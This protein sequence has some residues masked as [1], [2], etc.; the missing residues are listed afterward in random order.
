MKTVLET[1]QGGTSYLEKHGVDSARLN[2]EH[3]LSHVLDCKRM[4]LYLDFDRPLTEESLAPL[5]DLTKR[6]SEGE[7]LQHLLGSVDFLGREFKC[8][9]RA[10]V[11]RPETEQLVTLALEQLVQRESPAR[12]LDMGTGT[13]VIGLTLSLDG[14]NETEVILADRSADA[15]ALANENATSLEVDTSKISFVESDLFSNLEGKFDFLLAN[16]PYVPESDRESLSREVG[17]DPEMAL[18]ADEEG[19]A[20]I[21]RFI[22]DAIPFCAPDAWIGLEI[23]VAQAAPLRHNLEAAGYQSIETHRDFADIERFLTCR[24]PAS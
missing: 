5:R 12:V 19:M 2:M 20:V 18:F 15:L 8:D 7:P 17:H 23:G 11:P 4:D 22:K 24:T 3:L 1:I 10:L 14:P 16:L 6:R 13:G 21:R 9:P